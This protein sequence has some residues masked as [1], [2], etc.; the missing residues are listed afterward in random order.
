MT[1]PE[2]FKLSETERHSACW[3][4]LKEHLEEKLAECRRKNDGNLSHEDTMRLRGSINTLKNLLEVGEPD[5]PAP[6]A[7][8]DE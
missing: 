2:D 6:M 8:H 4:R 3:T 7:D 5:I 1:E